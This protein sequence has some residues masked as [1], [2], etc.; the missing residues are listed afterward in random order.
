MSSDITL[1]YCVLV[2]NH[3]DGFAWVRYNDGLK[4][5]ELDSEDNPNSRFPTLSAAREAAYKFGHNPNFW[6]KPDGLML[7]LNNCKKT[8][9]ETVSDCGDVDCR[10]W[11]MLKPDVKPFGITTCA[12]VDEDAGGIIAYV[13]DLETAEDVVN[14]LNEN[15]N[16]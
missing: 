8:D 10:F 16:L 1:K 12:I 11:I 13:H 15:Y 9:S 4:S 14:L 2:Y 5:T 3:Y 7:P 6:C